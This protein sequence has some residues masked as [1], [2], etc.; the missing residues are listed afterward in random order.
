MYSYERTWRVVGE[1][2]T[3][4]EGNGEVIEECG[5]EDDKED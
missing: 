2:R 1:K 3:V 4:T 5:C